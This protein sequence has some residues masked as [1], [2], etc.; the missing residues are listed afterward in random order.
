MSACDLMLVYA[1]DPNDKTSN[2]LTYYEEG[3]DWN[4]YDD[5]MMRSAAVRSGYR[6]IM[7]RRGGPY[8]LFVRDE[9]IE[10]S[11][12]EAALLAARIVS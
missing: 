12:E 5:D 11:T 9:I 8:V 1:L 6:Y 2:S 4:S 10:F 3:Y 7:R